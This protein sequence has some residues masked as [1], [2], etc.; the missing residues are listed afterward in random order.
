MGTPN[1]D[2]YSQGHGGMM[3]YGRTEIILCEDAVDLGRRAAGDVA[4]LMRDLLAQRDAVRIVLAAG[5][6]QNTFLD[7]LAAE[8]DLAWGRVTCF[9]MDEFWEPAMDRRFT[10]AFQLGR[11][12]YERVRPGTVHAIACHA[13]DAEAE[14]RRFAR[15]LQQAGPIDILCAGIGTSG[16]LAFNEPGQT[17]FDDSLDVRVVDIA[18]QSRRQ[19]M[20][21]PNFR[22]KGEIPARGITMTIPAL[23]RADHVFTIVPLGLKRDIL[24]RVLATP[25]PDEDL[26][27]TILSTAAGR[28]YVDR[29]SC[30][31]SLLNGRV[32]GS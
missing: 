16:H 20:D 2:P 15:A 25:E 22:E 26:P 1:D 3:Q 18:E 12:L 6:S 11:Q 8:P 23:L 13:P 19:L 9:N 32:T 24:T 14:A 5:E 28:L 21:D 4:A 27:A 30:P 29:D 10:C 7:A 17:R 31:V